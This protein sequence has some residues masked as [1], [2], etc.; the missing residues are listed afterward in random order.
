MTKLGTEIK[1][2]SEKEVVVERVTRE[3]KITC[4]IDAGKRR[5][6]NIDTKLQF[7]NHM[8]ETIGWRM[9]LNIDLKFEAT[10]FKLTHVI[11]EDSGIVLGS[12][13]AALFEKKMEKGVNGASRSIIDEG[14]ATAAVSIEGRPKLLL[15]GNAVTSLETV[16][17]T[18]T[19]DLDDFLDALE[20]GLFG[21]QMKT[22]LVFS[23]I[24]FKT[25]SAS[26]S[27]SS[28]RLALTAVPP[29][30]KVPDSISGYVGEIKTV[31]F[32]HSR[33]TFG[34]WFKT[35]SRDA[36]RPMLGISTPA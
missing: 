26:S 18:K 5:K 10:N 16:E 19:S 12:A 23:S 17:D 25:A 28:V 4:R 27:K 1:K 13:L 33:K 3:S 22:I 35:K 2:A 34:I 14:C 36:S 32:P 30:L 6:T 29:A 24:A 21:L 31:F 11:A 9:N 15:E 20:V 7:L 8:I